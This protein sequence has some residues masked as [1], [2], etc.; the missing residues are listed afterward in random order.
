[1]NAGLFQRVCA[2]ITVAKM[3][4]WHV[5]LMRESIRWRWFKITCSLFISLLDARKHIELFPYFIFWHYTAS[6]WDLVIW[7]KL[8][9]YLHDHRISWFYVRMM[10]CSSK[11]VIRFNL[12]DVISYMAWKNV[13]WISAR[14]ILCIWT[15]ILQIFTKFT[16]YRLSSFY[17]LGIF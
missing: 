17:L 16:I 15:R 1:M 11:S 2:A 4:P 8:F 9:W 7:I 6:H 3:Y 13:R 5:L 10:Q 14:L 12:A